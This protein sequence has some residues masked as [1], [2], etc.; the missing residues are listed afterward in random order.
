M[1]SLTSKGKVPQTFAM[2]VSF[3]GIL[4]NVSGSFD[5]MIHIMFT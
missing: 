4:L 5:K 3:G 2:L 1:K